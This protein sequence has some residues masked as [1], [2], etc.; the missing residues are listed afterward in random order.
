MYNIF[1]VLNSAYMVFGV[2]WIKS[3]HENVDLKKIKTIYI[4]DTGLKDDD[5]KFL[6]SYDKVEIIQSDLNEVSTSDAFPNN[7]IWLQ[8]VLRKTKYFRKILRMDQS[9]LVMVDSD[10]MFTGDFLKHLN[11]TD[12]VL[13]CNRSYKNY[14]NWIASFFVANNADNGIE[15]LNLWISRMKRLMK[16]QPNRGWFESHSLNLIIEEL[17]NDSDNKIKIG[18]V[19]TKNVACEEIKCYDNIG[20]NVVHF[21]GTDRKSNLISRFNRFDKIPEIKE[22]VFGY[23]NE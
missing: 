21:K 4:L 19:Y 10:C 7:S 16:E 2:V 3:L 12:D 6:E 18:D 1:T 15:F 8:H 20:T 22:K 14:D 13:V 23:L 17:K 11:N 5:I 9:P